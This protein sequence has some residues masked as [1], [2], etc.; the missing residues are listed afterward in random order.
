MQQQPLGGQMNRERGYDPI[1]LAAFFKMIFKKFNAVCDCQC[2]M[3]T[4]APLKIRLGGV[5]QDEMPVW[6]GGR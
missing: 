2:G 6:V 4:S 5:H 3:G 1:R